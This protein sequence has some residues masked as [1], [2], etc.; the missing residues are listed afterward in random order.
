MSEYWRESR[1]L[2]LSLFY[3]LPLVALYEVGL[4]V[5]GA[6][7]RNGADVLLKGLFNV[8]GPY[9]VPVLN[10]TFLALCLVAMFVLIRRGVR[11]GLYYPPL[12]LE[13]AIYGLTLG[14]LANLF[15][16]HLVPFQAGG[17]G[18]DELVVDL[19]L[20]VGAG[21]YEEIFFRLLLLSWVYLIGARWLALEPIAAGAIAIV[22]SAIA[23][24]AFH[25]IGIGGEPFDTPSFIFRLLGGLI[26]G[27]LFALR[28]LAIAVYAHTFYDIFFYLSRASA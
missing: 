23:F 8:F 5:S 19:L 6:R 26:L 16:Y 17:G 25:Y 18:E 7:W 11:V 10:V 27:T 15:R 24:S 9:G 2:A 14:P 1:G 20:S 28:G 4:I 3:I 12:V 22:V 13:A 21:V